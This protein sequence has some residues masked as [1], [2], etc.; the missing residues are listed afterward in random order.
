MN[1]RSLMILMLG[2]MLA[3][4]QSASEVKLPAAG[5]SMSS[6]DDAQPRSSRGYEPST[7]I[8][9]VPE[10][11]PADYP[12]M[13][14][15][16]DFWRGE[17]NAPEVSWSSPAAKMAQAWADQLKAEGCQIR[18]NMAAARRETYGENIY[19]YWRSQPY[20]GFRRD[21]KYVVNAWG[22]EKAYYDI[23]TN[24]CQP[25]AGGM[26]G[27]YTQVVWAQSLQVGCG[28]AQCGDSEVW[29]CDYY[30]RGN[31]IGLRPFELAANINVTRVPAPVSAAPAPRDLHP[32]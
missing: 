19:R 20:E 1:T 14:Q 16:H 32:E 4:C 13:L 9:I 29:V 25:P 12:G 18:H 3:A 24:S 6:A 17:V 21:S 8:V 26:C 31:Y 11:E 27:H 30:P 22:E 10:P 7:P 2:A 23:A 15:A 28:R 5:E